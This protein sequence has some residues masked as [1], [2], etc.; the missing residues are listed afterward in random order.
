MC[1]MLLMLAC[2]NP[3]Q[4]YL[5]QGI[6]YRDQEKWDEAIAAYTKAIEIDSKFANAYNNRGYA[7]FKK[8][9]NEA[10][11]ADFTKAIELEPKQTVPYKN[12]AWIY[13]TTAK[14]DKAKADLEKILELSKDS[15]EI[16]MVKGLLEKVKQRE[17]ETQ[18]I[19]EIQIPQN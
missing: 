9:N 8:E 6:S 19:R 11:I 3:A 2:A 1:T 13:V 18:P 15:S 12:R 16:E 7:Y 10:A 4:K 5:D 17:E 14:Y